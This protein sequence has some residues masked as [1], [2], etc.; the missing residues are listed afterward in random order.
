[1]SVYTLNIDPLEHA[2]YIVNTLQDRVAVAKKV[3]GAGGYQGKNP[4]DV[5]WQIFSPVANNQVTWEANYSVFASNITVSDGAVI[6]QTAPLLTP[7]AQSGIVY[8]FDGTSVKRTTETGTVGSYTIR[9]D[10]PKVVWN[11]GLSQPNNKSGGKF[12]SVALTPAGPGE[13]AEFTPHETVYVFLTKHTQDGTITISKW[14]PYVE[15]TLQP[16][17]PQTLHFDKDHTKFFVDNP[18]K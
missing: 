7:P 8:S 15:V 9:N 1:M 17:V 10:A 14:S 11:L 18:K 4:A 6:T 3:D 16:D 12:T 13:T 5:A 2:D